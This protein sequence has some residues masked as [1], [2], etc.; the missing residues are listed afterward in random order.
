LSLQRLHC[1][2]GLGWAQPTHLGRVRPS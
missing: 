1:S 2:H